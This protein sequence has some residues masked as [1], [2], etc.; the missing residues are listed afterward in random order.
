MKAV[1]F[2]GQG[3]QLKGMGRSL[4]AAYPAWVRE[5]SDILGYAID[6]LCL[7]N[8]QNQL[9]Q[10]QYTQPA[11]YVVN[12][13]THRKLLEDQGAG[14]TADFLAGHSLGEYNALMAAGV[15]DFGT[16]LRLVKRRGEL[17]GA[18]ADGGMAAVIG[19]EADAIRRVLHGHQLDD[20]DVANFN[21]PMQLVLAGKRASIARA[22]K[23]FNGLGTRCVVLNVS[24]PFHSRYMADAA[25]EFDT[26]SRQFHFE[27]PRIPVIANVTARPYGANDVRET[28]CRQIASPVQ[29]VDSIRYLMAQ[30]ADF[31]CI[32]VGSQ[33]LSKMVEETRRTATPLVLPVVAEPVA[34]PPAPEPLVQ[35]MAPGDISAA[36]LGSDVFK[37]RYRLSHAYVS[38]GMY[39]GIAS[40]DLVVRM[41]RAGLL[42]FL[43][44][45]GCSLQ[46][47]EDAVRFIQA[48]LDKGEPYGVNLLANYA[49][50]AAER[51]TV[52]VFLSLGVQRI[53]A[54]AFMQITPALVLYRLRGLSRTRE[55]QIASSTHVVAKVSRPEVA[56]AFMSPAPQAMVSQLLAEGAIT[57]EQAQLSPSVP[58][59]SDLCVE[60]D[61]GG[62]T[63]G[64]I[65]S[66]LLPAMLRLRDELVAQHRFT[67]EVGVGLGGGIGTPEA[68][69]AAFLMGADFIVTGSIN[70][71][72]VEAAMSDDVKDMLQDMNVQDTEYAPAGDMFETGAK[73]QVLKKGVFFAGRA[74]RLHALYTQHTSLEE[75]PAAVRQQLEVTYFKRS[76]DEVWK[77]TM[78]Y[79]R[80]IGRPQ[81]IDKANAQP[82]HKMSLVFRWYFA[83][84][85]A[86]AFSGQRQD[87]VNYQVHTGPALG[88]FNQWVK[89]TEL[90]AWRHRHVDAIGL[91]LMNETAA[92]LNRSFSRLSA[93]RSG[94]AHALGPR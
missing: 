8:P 32:E 81:E 29:W 94:V 80:R 41:G 57:A 47:I 70:Q 74:N 46:D 48:R 21:T 1:F 17:M 82:K 68:A 40:P 11:I 73:V 26:F 92:Y 20:I 34:A 33:I 62:H 16:G 2:P 36:S 77:E 61:S 58:V 49:D 88:A 93:R 86:L 45:G 84:A 42:G 53:E 75:I 5:A 76:L 90:E 54:A 25:R 79:L 60:A 67:V 14:F 6:T 87:R 43:G 38:G 7:D 91:R 3:T 66:V 10:T 19:Q 59:C 50:P 15:F 85:T 13:L 22:E 63:D 44:T 69:A 56:R 89:G 4:F 31:Q 30:Q 83:H 23:I 37:R 18:A 28:L 24:A 27:A 55:G 65:P 12:A 71:C 39:R 9:N 35:D 52:E 78:D 51:Q 72:T 64:G